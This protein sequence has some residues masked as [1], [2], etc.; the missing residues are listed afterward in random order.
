MP[1]LPGAPV[2]YVSYGSNMSRERFLCYLQ[3]GV[4]PGGNR[5]NPGARDPRPPAADRAV[6]LAGTAY[7]AADSTQWH[8]GIMFYDHLLPG[9]TAARAYL[10]TAGQLCDVAIQEMHEEPD[11]DH[12]LLDLDITRLTGG[13][14]AFGAGHYETLV[15]VGRAEDDVPMLTFTSPHGATEVEHRRP[16][17]AYLEVIAQGLRESRDWSEEQI[18]A[19]LQGLQE[20]SRHSGSRPE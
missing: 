15:E 9:F 5:R 17:A 18:G 14:H 2:W 19:Y 6:D 13:R 20:S 1:D 4:P 16:S 10:V 11:G 3:G 12:P 8:G 7:F